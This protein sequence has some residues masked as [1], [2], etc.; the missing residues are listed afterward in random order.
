MAM[1]LV[2]VGI[3][4]GV[5]QSFTPAA[6][7]QGPRGSDACAAGNVHEPTML[8]GPGFGEVDEDSSVIKLRQ[9]PRWSLHLTSYGATVRSASRVAWLPEGFDTQRTGTQRWSRIGSGII[10]CTYQG[11]PEK[12]CSATN[13]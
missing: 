13:C 7:A 2:P 3:F 12:H 1:P 9:L 6:G 8:S 11:T 10:R 4:S 5:R